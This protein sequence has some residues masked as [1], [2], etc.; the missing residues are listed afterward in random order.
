MLV[1]VE[2]SCGQQ[3]LASQ[4]RLMARITRFFAAVDPGAQLRASST[5]THH[6]ARVTYSLSLEVSSSLDTSSF[7]STTPHHFLYCLR[8]SF[9]SSANP[10]SQK[11][12][13]FRAPPILCG[14]SPHHELLPAMIRL[15]VL[16]ALMSVSRSRIMS[17][18]REHQGRTEWQG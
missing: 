14:V 8:N 1:E 13:C 17:S 3:E 11:L 5:R 6:D 7:N 18:Q 12:P 4:G 15:L 10:K 9:S 2:T 16:G